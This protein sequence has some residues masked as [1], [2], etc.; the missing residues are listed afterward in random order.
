MDFTGLS[1]SLE[2]GLHV[3]LEPGVCF[4]LV[5]D[6]GDAVADAETVL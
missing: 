4:S 6:K 3:L 5:L 2:V 1:D